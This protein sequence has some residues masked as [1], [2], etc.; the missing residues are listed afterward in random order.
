M[1]NG[2]IGVD[3]VPGEGSTFWFQVRLDVVEEATGQS[4]SQPQQVRVLVVDDCP[5]RRAHVQHQLENWGTVTVGAESGAKALHL[6]LAQSQEAVFDLVVAEAEMDG[7]DGL[8]L[9]RSLQKESTLAGTPFVLISSRRFDSKQL[10]RAGVSRCLIRPVQQ[11][12][13]YDS[14]ASFFPCRAT[15]RTASRRGKKEPLLEGAEILLV[16]DNPVIQE[17]VC[18]MIANL[19]GTVELVDNGREALNATLARDFD[20]VLMDCQMPIMDGYEATRAIR[21]SYQALDRAE[22][23]QGRK[24]A[25]IVAMTA[26]AMAGD[27]EKCLAAG[28][29]D[30][31]SKPFTQDELSD[32][33]LRWFQ[34]KHLQA[35]TASGAEATEVTPIRGARA[36]G[37]RQSQSVSDNSPLDGRV[38]DRLRKISPNGDTVL[39]KVVERYLEAT[40]KLIE[41]LQRAADENDSDGLFRAAHTLKSSSGMLGAGHLMALCRELEH[42]GKADS[43]E[44][45]VAKL[46]ELRN[47]YDLVRLALAEQCLEVA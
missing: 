29:D 19:G 44:G 9:A 3:S 12:H 30:Y 13:L 8:T 34:P 1:M 26:N 47:E 31:V 46:G 27:R 10:D 41:T 39:R 15:S 38:L 21:G 20:L 24:R 16:E 32:V 4:H 25:T 45:A 14:L 7:V 17:V 33:L 36:V 23:G 22:P 43:T 40:P 11:S 2:E 35:S 18:S 28:M 5:E 6:L 37:G 42:I